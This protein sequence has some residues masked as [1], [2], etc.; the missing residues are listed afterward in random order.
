[1][2]FLIFS[3]HKVGEE[4]IRSRLREVWPDAD[5]RRFTGEL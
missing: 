4:L 3:K 5:L 2:K 1:M